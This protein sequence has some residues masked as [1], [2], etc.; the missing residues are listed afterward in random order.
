MAQHIS[1]LDACKASGTIASDISTTN[2]LTTSGVGIN[3]KSDRVRL[4]VLDKAIYM[5]VP[6]GGVLFFGDVYMDAIVN[7]QDG[8]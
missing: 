2:T 5:D 1:G 3:I 7:G 4:R 8:I 6:P